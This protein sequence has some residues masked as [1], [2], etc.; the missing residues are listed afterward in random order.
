MGVAT[1]AAEYKQV[2]VLF[3]DM[4]RSMDLAAAL[5]MER[6]RDLVTELVERAATAVR[7][8]GGTVEYTGDGVMALFGAPTALEDHAYRACLAAMAV[9]HEAAEMDRVVRH[10]DGVSLRVRV[11]LDS[12]RVIAGEIGS[13]APRYAATGDTVGF[14]HRMESAAPPGGVLLSEATARLVEHKV[15][16]AAP[17]S[18][19]IKGRDGPVP[20]R[21]LT[22][23]GPREEAPGRIEASLV[24]RGPEMAALA[25]MLDGAAQRR[26]G[27]ANVVGAPGIGKSRVAR[28]AAALAAGR[29]M[30]VFWTFCESHARDIPFYAV[31]RLLRASRGVT[32]VDADTARTLV[33]RQLPDADPLDVHLLEDLL[34][35]VD[36]SVPVPQLDPD[37]RRSRLTGLISTVALARTH[38]ALF[39]IEDAHW[40]DAVSETLIADFLAVIARTSSVV[41]ITSRPEYDGPLL[42]L[43]GA[44]PLILAPLADSDVKT[45]LGELIGSDPSVGELAAVIAE[46]GAGNPFF[47]E[48]IVRELV[49]RGAFGGEPGGYTC[50]TDAAE[51]GVPATV[52][53]AI[54]ARLDRLTAPARATLNAASVIGARFEPQL[55]SALGIDAVLDELL[56]AELIDTVPTGSEYAFRH[57]LIRAVAYES[58]LKSDRAEWH[59]RL[60]G[61][62]QQRAAGSVEDN[63]ALIAEHLE[64]AGDLAGA[65][66]W[67]M[68]AGG[69]LTN[70]DLAAARLSWKRATTIADRL[71]VDTPDQ[72]A[73]RIAPRTMLCATDIQAREIRDSQ[74]RFAELQELCSAAGD[75]VSLAIAM[76]GPATELMYAG[77][78]R[79]A[80]RVSSQQMALLESI[81]DPAPAMGLAAVA[82]CTWHGVLEFG[83]ILRW[84]QTIVDLAA[85]DPGRGAGFGIGSP[86][87]IAL[88]FRGTSRWCLGQPGWCQ[89]LHDAVALAR[90]SNAETLS[91]TIAWSYGF[92]MQY[93]LLPADDRMLAAG[94]HAVQTALGA[95]TD[96][97]LGLAGYTW[98]VALLD[99]DDEADRGHG[100]DLMMQTRELWLGKGALF[101]IPATDVWIAR[102]TARRGDPDAA[103]A[104][105]RTAV[106][107]LYRVYPFYALW[108]TGVLVQT[109]LDRDARGDLAEAR[110]AVERLARTMAD[111]DSTAVAITLL[112]QRTMLARAA[113]DPGAPGL[114]RRYRTMAESLGFQG[115]M[116]WARELAG[117]TG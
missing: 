93:G 37:S 39:V 92:A 62:I 76:S 68:R 73:K 90:R 21:R 58:Q 45:L 99:Q 36:P 18:V 31:T 82:F 108:A 85:G 74:G 43:P 5:D 94:A 15:A 101:L 115:H 79:E 66:D 16:L 77:R 102:E 81:D 104:A 27:V 64:A 42:R 10:R 14:A 46:R 117:G 95:S 105:L 89:D 3:A 54:E 100:L 112:R 88:A 55:L 12:G 106:D 24:G 87:A 72:V 86:L 28:E 33:R 48:E 30:E 35:I 65:Y 13:G 96:R 78:V 80:A 7:R 70:R 22:G 107:E 6:L 69:W 109:L 75:K 84:S 56:R 111:H 8:Y 1:R 47:V 44:R 49:Q 52:A 20:A 57:P 9:Q 61:A 40:I 91:A 53:A 67:H 98:A 19:H 59:R 4:V 34:G 103:V 29:G 2:T 113:G 11:G 38:P 83:D 110:R 32:G 114:A 26:G 41:L 23:I 50:R 71:P 116:A 25:A 63:A 17:E 51:V 97:A 60:A